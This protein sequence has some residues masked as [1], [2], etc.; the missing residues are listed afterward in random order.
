M[1]IMSEP[2]RLPGWAGPVAG[3]VAVVALVIVGLTRGPAEF[4]PGSPE[5]TIQLYIEALVEGDFD[6]AASFWD[7]SGCFPASS[8]PSGGSPGASASLVRVEG[9]DIEATVVVRLT[10]SSPDPLGGLYDYEEW[11]TLVRRG[12]SWQIRQPSWPYY[13]LPCEDSP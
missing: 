3:V 6:T 12:D 10:E 2:Q 1:L 5:G 11:F 13:E 7:E 9:N 8:I 4:D